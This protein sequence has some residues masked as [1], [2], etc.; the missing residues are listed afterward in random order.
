M[1]SH[2]YTPPHPLPPLLDDLADELSSI[3]PAQDSRPRRRSSLPDIPLSDLDPD[4]SRLLS[5]PPAARQ[6]HHHHHVRVQ[7]RLA[8]VRSVSTVNMRSPTAGSTSPTGSVPPVPRFEPAVG[9]AV[10]LG[11]KGKGKGRRQRRRSLDDEF[12]DGGTETEREDEERQRETVIR[13]TQLRG[14]GIGGVGNIR[15]PIDVV[16]FTPSNT[17]NRMSSLLLF[18]ST[19]PSSPTSLTSPERRKWNLREIFGLD[20][21][22]KGKASA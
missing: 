13:D 1:R 4:T 9:S 10:A 18:S 17:S 3:L 19:A 8:L 6:R 12:R 7:G 14:Y 20:R 16:H 15:R 22:P 2:P 11:R 5:P 21:R